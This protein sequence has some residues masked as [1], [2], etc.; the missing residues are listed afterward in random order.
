[1]EKGKII[2]INGVSSAGK[3]TLSQTL[4]Q[5]FTEQYFLIPGD[6]VNDISPPKNSPS[7]NLRF[8]AD[9]KPVMSSV[10]GCAKAFAD[11]GLN[12][13]VETI[14]TTDA[15]FALDNFLGVFPNDNYPI[16]FALLTCPLE[17]LRRREKE[18]GDRQ[19]GWGE[20]L[21]AKLD[22]PNTYDIIIDTYNSTKE[23]CA[24]EII[25]LANSPERFMAFKT[26]WQQRC[27]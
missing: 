19:I 27:I 15:H 13:I 21:L 6:I 9:P 11:N 26:L 4:Q 8:T 20:S 18:R 2:L 16:L 5:R 7:Y 10:F 22:P 24:D 3:T 1:M 14:F 17:E 25:R 12:V 23:E